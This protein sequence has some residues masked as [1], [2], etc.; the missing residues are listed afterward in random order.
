MDVQQGDLAA[1]APR[2]DWHRLARSDEWRLH[3]TSLS[4]LGVWVVQKVYESS[5]HAEE[6]IQDAKDIGLTERSLEAYN[7]SEGAGL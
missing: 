4:F 1:E 5:M 7:S 6:A 2:P 3:L